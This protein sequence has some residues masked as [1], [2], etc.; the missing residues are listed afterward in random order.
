[1][2]G[3]ERS[4]GTS[5]PRRC[6]LTSVGGPALRQDTAG[7]LGPQAHRAARVAGWLHTGGW[8][9]TI[10]PTNMTSLMRLRTASNDLPLDPGCTVTLW[11]IIAR[12]V[13]QAMTETPRFFAIRPCR[14]LRRA[15]K[16]GLGSGMPR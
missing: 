5:K 12:G 13:P 4:M 15:G 1:M 9:R 7:L 11:S 10:K 2:G 8:R 16:S 6:R 14:E 3:P